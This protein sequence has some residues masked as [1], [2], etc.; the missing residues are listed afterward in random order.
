VNGRA[1]IAVLVS[2]RG[3]NLQ[4]LIEASRDGRLPGDVVQ[5]LCDRVGSAAVAR[6]RSAGIEDVRELIAAGFQSREAFDAALGDALEHAHCDVIAC[7]GFMRVLG[8]AFIRR[9]SGRMLNIHPS[10]LPRHPG[11]RT[12]EAVIAAGEREHGATVHFV[13][14]AL[15]SGPRVIQGGFMVK[16][17][18]DVRTL[19]ER[20]LEQIELRIFPQSVAWLARGELS[21]EGT[22]ARWRGRWLAAPLTLDDLDAE[23]R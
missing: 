9:F 2:G 7:A 4:T 5:V 23:F 21:L 12:H 13:T 22:M 17:E 6:A 15:D 18:D 10:L 8:A 16:A 3:R 1:R 19:A 11:L 14:E 20:V